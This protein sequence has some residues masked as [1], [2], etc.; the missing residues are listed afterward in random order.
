M[1]EM[2][3][4]TNIPPELQHLDFSKEDPLILQA[5]IDG[6]INRLR[7]NGIKDFWPGLQ[8]QGTPPSTIDDIHSDLLEIE[9]SRSGPAIDVVATPIFPPRLEQ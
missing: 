3:H 2:Q 9:A 8:L 7:R 1:S 6:L 5:R 4:P